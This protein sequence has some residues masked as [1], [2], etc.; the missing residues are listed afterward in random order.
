MLLKPT[1]L[2]SC[3]LVGASFLFG[4]SSND[5]TNKADKINDERIDKQ[6][7]AVSNDAKED[8]KK[9]SRYLVHLS[10]SGTTEFELSKVALQKATNPEVRGFAQRAMNEHQQ[11]DKALQSLAKQMNVTL[12]A[13]L[14]D[15][16]KTSLGKLTEM[17]PGTEFDLQYLDNMATVNDDALEVADDLQ[18]LSPNDAVKAFAKKLS[19]NDGKHKDLAKQLKNILD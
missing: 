19:E 8:A 17:K 2:L 6:A 5:S 18:D 4:C 10:N 7:I 12:P 16:S 13:E 15:N 14:S 1:T 9:V 3:A 11:N